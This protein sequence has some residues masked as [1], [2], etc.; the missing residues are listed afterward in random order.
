MLKKKLFVGSYKYK[1]AKK[2]FIPKLDMSN[3]CFLTIG[4]FQDKIIQQAFLQVLQ[5]IFEGVFV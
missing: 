2:V 4:S 3:K 1:P 5:Q